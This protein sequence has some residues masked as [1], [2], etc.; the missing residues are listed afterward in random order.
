MKGVIKVDNEM[1]QTATLFSKIDLGGIAKG[2]V[3]DRV[4]QLLENM[5]DGF[6]M[7]VGYS[8]LWEFA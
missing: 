7:S 4:S 3:I 1:K 5:G 6:I 2:W 8:Y